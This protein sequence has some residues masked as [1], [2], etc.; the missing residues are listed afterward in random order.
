LINF[1]TNNIEKYDYV[2]NTL[3]RTYPQGMDSEI[4]SFDTLKEAHFNAY[5]PFD[6]EHVT[7]FIIRRPSR[8]RLHNIEHSTN[9]SHYRLTIDTSED[10]DLVKKIFKEL[11]F[12]NPE[13]KMKDILTVLEVNSEWL[14]INSHVKQW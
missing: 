13:F 9:L 14:S 1:Y 5:D 3:K 4:I 12:T 8:Y 2:S 6:R 11:F 10:L 7:P